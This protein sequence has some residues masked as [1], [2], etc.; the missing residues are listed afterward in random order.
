MRQENEIAGGYQKVG[1]GDCKRIA[2]GRRRRLQE[3]SRRKE[4]G[5]VRG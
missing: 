2:G 5:I 4:K 1:E 3:D